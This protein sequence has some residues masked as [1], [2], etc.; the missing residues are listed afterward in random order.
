MTEKPEA[1]ALKPTKRRPGWALREALK[2]PDGSRK[3]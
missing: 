2:E 1:P 3:F